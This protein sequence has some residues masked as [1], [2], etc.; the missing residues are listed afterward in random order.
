MLVGHVARKAVHLYKNSQS[1]KEC[2]SVRLL[3]AIGPQTIGPEIVNFGVPLWP[4]FKYEGGDVPHLSGWVGKSAGP[5]GPKTLTHKNPYMLWPRSKLSH[6]REV[7]LPSVCLI[8]FSPR[9]R[10]Q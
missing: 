4:P 6:D 5:I 7:A 1:E 2:V 3:G 8:F 9:G 10:E